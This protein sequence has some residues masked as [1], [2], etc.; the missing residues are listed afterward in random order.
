MSESTQAPTTVTDI[1]VAMFAVADQD[2]A[3]DF[4][5]NTLGWVKAMDA[6][7]SPE[8]RWL[9]VVPPGATTQLVLA[10]PSWRGGT[11]NPSPNRD[12]GISLIAPDIDATYETLAARGVRFK[13]PVTVMPWGTK[14]TWFYDLDGNEFF[15]T[16]E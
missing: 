3:L 11:S 8:M 1:G 15:L 10:L 9:T 13:Q 5:L 12:S 2:A 14:A 6:P 16:A 7:V 4:Y